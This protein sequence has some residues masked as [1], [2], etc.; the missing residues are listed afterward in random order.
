MISTKL[1]QT[2]NN[3]PYSVKTGSFPLSKINTKL[4]EGVQKGIPLFDDKDKF[5]SMEDIDFITRNFD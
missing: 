3:L 2:V 5:V 4:L 1:K